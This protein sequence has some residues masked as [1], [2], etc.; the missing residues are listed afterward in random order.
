MPEAPSLNHLPTISIIV[1]L[2]NE[3]QFIG[4]CL[5]SLVE[6]EYP[7]N[8]KEIIVVDNGSCDSSFEIASEFDVTLLK[9][10]DVKVGAV[11]NFGVHHAK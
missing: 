6:C 11:R 5:E 9:I 4:K 2:Y 10:V 1:P 3:E 8:K 7:S